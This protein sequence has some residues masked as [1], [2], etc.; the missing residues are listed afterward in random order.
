MLVYKKENG[1]PVDITF[2]TKPCGMLDGYI[3]DVI[4]DGKLVETYFHRNMRDRIEYA[5]KIFEPYRKE[6]KNEI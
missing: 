5:E 4:I 1:F 2:D 3:S 6:E